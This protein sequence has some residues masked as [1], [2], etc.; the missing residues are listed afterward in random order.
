M[1]RGVRECLVRRVIRDFQFVGV[2]AAVGIARHNATGMQASG[3]VGVLVDQPGA[4]SRRSVQ[5]LNR[6]I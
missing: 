1:F 3:S 2:E 5:L 6:P 4:V